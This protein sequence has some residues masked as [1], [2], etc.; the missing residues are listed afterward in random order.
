MKRKF[1]FAL[2]VWALICFP[3]EALCELPADLV[4]SE[5]SEILETADLPTP[6]PENTESPV[7]MET[8]SEAD[9][10]SSEVPE[11]T[12]TA[13]EETAPAELPELTPLPETVQTDDVSRALNPEF[14]CGYVKLTGAATGYISASPA[15]QATVY[16]ESGVFYASDRRISSSGDRIRV[17]FSDGAETRSVWIDARYLRSMSD[18]EIAD[19]VSSRSGKSGVHYYGGDMRLPLDAPDYSSAVTYGLAT[20]APRAS[21]P[22]MFVSQTHLSLCV[23][24]TLPIHVSFSDGQSYLV[25]FSSDDNSVAAISGDG[26]IIGVSAGNT[27]IRLKS[28]HGNEAA[29][30]IQ[31]NP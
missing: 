10:A 13:S 20:Q 28:E 5:I 16:L 17:H 24:E 29:I 22:A 3:L 21:V 23:G 12:P 1:L 30:E 31:V 6:A 26:S 27:C 15:A 2:S 14:D 4:I 25:Y 7:E 8:P 9:S 11:P 19:F 18:A